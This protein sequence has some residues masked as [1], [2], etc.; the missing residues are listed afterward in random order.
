MEFLKL[1]FIW[2]IKILYFIIRLSPSKIPLNTSLGQP[3]N[4]LASDNKS[5]YKFMYPRHLMFGK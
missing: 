5:F 2:S 3:L 4:K 1:I